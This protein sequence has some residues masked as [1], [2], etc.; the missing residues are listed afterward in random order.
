MR[1]GGSWTSVLRHFV[2]D[3][4]QVRNRCT[5]HHRENNP[6]SEGASNILHFHEIKVTFTVD[7][8]GLS[9]KSYIIFAAPTPE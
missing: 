5:V 9:Y 8:F 2:F 4:I 6:E 3:K 7:V 1:C